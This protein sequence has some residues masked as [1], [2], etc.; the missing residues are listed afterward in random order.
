M[1]ASQ[2]LR[3]LNEAAYDAIKAVKAEPRADID[4]ARLFAIA[5]STD[6][7]VDALKPESRK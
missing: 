4:T 3:A 2:A 5:H 7:L 1:T 6:A